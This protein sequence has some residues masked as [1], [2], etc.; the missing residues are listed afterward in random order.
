MRLRMARLQIVGLKAHLAGTVRTLHRLGCVQIED[1]SDA[2]AG[3]EMRMSA[4]PAFLS[5]S[6]DCTAVASTFNYSVAL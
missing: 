5:H 6:F 4:R 3:S 2:N 1:V